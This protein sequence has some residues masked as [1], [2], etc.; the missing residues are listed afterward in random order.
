MYL[1]DLFFMLLLVTVV[2]TGLSI[3]I[4]DFFKRGGKNVQIPELEYL[5]IVSNRTKELEKTFKEGSFSITFIDL[6][7]AI[8]SGIYQIFKLIIDAMSGLYL[9][10]R[11]TV[12]VYLN[13][14]AWFVDIIS[15]SVS[16]FVLFEIIS[17]VMKYRL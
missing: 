2:F 5:N 7:F 16:I 3:F 4:T 6:P 8:L 13:L 11:N 10:F 17:A 12:S 1:R 15:V 14:P 9:T